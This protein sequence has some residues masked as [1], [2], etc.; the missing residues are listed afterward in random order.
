[1]EGLNMKSMRG[2][3]MDMMRVSELKLVKVRNIHYLSIQGPVFAGEM[4]A[5]GPMAIICAKNET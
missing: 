3:S 5:L 2:D 1:M 4:G